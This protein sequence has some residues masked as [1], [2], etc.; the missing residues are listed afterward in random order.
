[1]SPKNAST[2]EL[3]VGRHRVAVSNPEKVL[4]PE[5]G[6]TKADLV[7]ADASPRR[8]GLANIAGRLATVGDPC[9]HVPERRSSLAGA[10]R[11]LDGLVREGA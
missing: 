4:F 10:R 6:F 8:Y 1:M 9:E 2:Q 3:K 7:E 5:D 11:R